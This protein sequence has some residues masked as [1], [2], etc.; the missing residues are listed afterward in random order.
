MLPSPSLWVGMQLA[1]PASLA[2]GANLGFGGRPG[3][4]F[5][6]LIAVRDGALFESGNVAGGVLCSECCGRKF[7]S[8]AA[9]A[10][11]GFSLGGK[12]TVPDTP[13]RIS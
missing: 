2:V 3:L 1:G 8:V 4:R 13:G 6:R 7:A 12:I 9:E 11:S 10:S 5:C